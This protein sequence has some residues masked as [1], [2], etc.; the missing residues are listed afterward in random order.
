MLVDINCCCALYPF[1]VAI[2]N[3]LSA[4][5]FCG[6]FTACIYNN[7]FVQIHH[8]EYHWVTSACLPDSKIIL[9]DSAYANSFSD[10]L[11]IQLTQLYQ[12]K[13]DTPLKIYVAKVQQQKKGSGDCGVFAIASAVEF[14]FERYIWYRT[15]MLRHKKDKRSP[16]SVSG[17]EN[18]LQIPCAT[19]Q[20]QAKQYY[21]LQC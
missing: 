1:Q 11:K 13:N 8:T 5:T 14:C 18:V 9:M 20:T 19:M 4:E 3:I 17:E 6:K 16:L 10:S 2:W 15:F 12:R 21:S 7:P